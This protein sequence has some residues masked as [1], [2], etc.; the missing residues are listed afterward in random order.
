MANQGGEE[1]KEEEGE[2]A[3]EAEEDAVDE[4]NEQPIEFDELTHKMEKSVHTSS[5]N[6]VSNTLK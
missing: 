1:I 4:K 2:A 3:V 6:A 5:T